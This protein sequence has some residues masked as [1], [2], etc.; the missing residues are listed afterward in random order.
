[1]RVGERRGALIAKEPV[2][3]TIDALAAIVTTHLAGLGAR[4]TQDLRI[5]AV[6]DAVVRQVRT[7]MA[8]AA[9]K[10]ADETRRGVV[11]RWDLTGPPLLLL[12]KVRCKAVEAPHL[13]FVK[14]IGE[15]L[16]ANP[17][18]MIFLKTMA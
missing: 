4:C 13:D 10:L 6:I 7:E 9:N 3:A 8:I 1:M 12:P 17:L 16:S 18:M 15:F 5:R 2:D 11:R 14:R